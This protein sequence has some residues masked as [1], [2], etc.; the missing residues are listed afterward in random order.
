MCE[1]LIPS[2][3]HGGEAAAGPK[4]YEPLIVQA[5]PNPFNASVEIRYFVP[6]ADRQVDIRIYDVGGRLAYEFP[7]IRG[8]PGWGVA[9]WSGKSTSGSLAS[10]G[11]YF[12]RLTCEGFG[13]RFKKIALLR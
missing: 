9:V 5:I 10:S 8:A 12:L 1:T 4:S 2:A 3:V 11:I 6:A 7:R 13:P